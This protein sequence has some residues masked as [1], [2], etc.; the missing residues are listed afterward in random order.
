M[1][2]PAPTEP[3]LVSALEQALVPL[4]F[5]PREGGTFLAGWTRKT[6][7]TNRGVA[8]VRLPDG[9]DPVAFVAANRA[10]LA[11]DL[12]YVPMLYRIGIQL[13]LLGKPGA[14]PLD[15]AVDR[16]NNQRIIVQSVC[17]VDLAEGTVT[18]ARTWGQIITGRFQDAIGAAIHGI[19][20]L[21][22]APPPAVETPGWG[23]A[24]PWLVAL[25]G[26]MW[27]IRWL[28]S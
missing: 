6:L 9:I 7:G 20:G 28:L 18:A 10:N 11:R 14:S 24:L 16:I 1:T 8:V 12:G 21:P 27:V 13:V 19:L 2:E 23:R 5:K 4:G 22:A 26:V 3:D 25:V 15:G 17:V